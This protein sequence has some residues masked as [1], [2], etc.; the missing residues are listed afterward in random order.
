MLC[1]GCK[2]SEALVNMQF[3]NKHLCR[4]C[5]EDEVEGYVT[6]EDCYK[7]L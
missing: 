5:F 6:T 2:N 4:E 7:S 1:E 3:G